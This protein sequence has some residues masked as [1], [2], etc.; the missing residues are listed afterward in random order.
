MM[1]SRSGRLKRPRWSPKLL[2]WLGLAMI[3]GGGLWSAPAQEAGDRS[4]RVEVRA[5]ELQ[6]YRDAVRRHFV[7][8][9]YE[10][11]LELTEQYGHLFPEDES[12]EFY[13]TQAEL[14]LAEAERTIPF[15]RL[16]DRP[17]KIPGADEEA[18]TLL[19]VLRENG[20]TDILGIETE[21]GD[22]GRV[23]M[24]F[25][26]S[27]ERLPA[28]LEAPAGFEPREVAPTS[29]PEPDPRAAVPTDPEAESGDAPPP[30]P[31]A[32]LGEADPE[33]EIAAASDDSS[34]LLMILGGSVLVLGAIAAFLLL[35]I[36]RRGRRT[37]D[38]EPMAAP[39][40]AEAGPAPPLFQFDEPEDLTPTGAEF[41]SGEADV[42][43][44]A[45]S[46]ESPASAE[47]TDA[48]TASP[49]GET[50]VPDVNQDISDLLFAP[51]TS[52]DS[53]FSAPTADSAVPSPL[54]ETRAAGGESADASQSDLVQ[55]S[56]Y[57]SFGSESASG[58][59]GMFES[60]P[61]PAAP[62]ASGGGLD[63][64]SSID[65]FG[66]ETSGEEPGK[67]P[68]GEATSHL[69]LDAL[70]VGDSSMGSSTASAPADPGDSLEMEIPFSLEDP[71]QGLS[72]SGSGHEQ[73]SAPAGGGA[74]DDQTAF[75]SSTA[76]TLT[77]SASDSETS[78]EERELLEVFEGGESEGP[79]ADGSKA[80]GAETEAFDLWSDTVQKPP[81]G[82]EGTPPEPV[83]AFREDQT[84][85]VEFA[86]VADEEP[87]TEMPP[88]RPAAPADETV[89]SGSATD[90]D[91]G[92]LP[93]DP[94]EREQVRGSRAYDLENWDKAVHHL[95][96]AVAL[97]PDANEVRDQ[98]RRARKMRKEQRGGE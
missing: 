48:G 23:A 85:V 35:G 86:D 36:V 89:P 8:R 90:T 44:D 13:R 52:G 57:E 83:Q 12:T 49:L 43:A 33:A 1:M 64:L 58:Q 47:V 11:L 84:A 10:Q 46:V 87:P 40:A 2:V 93:D 25:P 30:S 77:G 67:P 97:R 29:V 59:E 71:F 19:E 55:I 24:G 38:A 45:G 68:A 72:Q 4:P 70:A 96:I 9:E 79:A 82:A 22:N 98:L 65:L 69:D 91:L 66:D 26:P 6:R 32:I 37:A 53:A 61:A 88:P 62:P 92:D 17:F 63:D 5:M 14:R 7:L 34:P 51:E 81:S 31:E 76:E 42:F 15:Q 18:P 28:P 27:E 73:A 74:E 94:F 39:S 41:D 3:A 50:G 54:G 60:G 21:R 75:Q 16:Q 20:G 56:D 78:H 95:S 80:G